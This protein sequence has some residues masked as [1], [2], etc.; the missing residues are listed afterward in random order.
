MAEQERL[1]PK[2]TAAQVVNRIGAGATEI[3]N[4][5]IGGL[6]HIDGGEFAGAQQTGDGA[7]VALV[8][9]E[10][11]ARLLGDE[12]RGGDQAG[13]LELLEATGDAKAA[14]ARL[15]GDLQFGAWVSFADACSAR[16]PGREGNW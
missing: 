3:A 16:S 8:G 11:R 4:G 5:L 10:G 12:G 15:V 7:G 6:R 1:E 2:A 13:H 14:G 9:F